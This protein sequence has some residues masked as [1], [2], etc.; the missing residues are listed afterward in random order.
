[1]AGD[2][3]V[4]VKLGP[5]GT[6]PSRKDAC[7]TFY[8]RRAVQSAIAD[9]VTLRRALLCVNGVTECKFVTQR[10]RANNWLINEYSKVVSPSW[11]LGSL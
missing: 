6:D 8:T 5:K 9:L 7:F 2:D 3:R 4:P 10:L 11:K 1:M